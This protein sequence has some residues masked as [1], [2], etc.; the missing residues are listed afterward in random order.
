MPK[1]SSLLQLLER[2]SAPELREIA[3]GRNLATHGTRAKLARRISYDCKRDMGEVV[4]ATGPWSRE[5]WN[6]FV[7]RTFNGA[8]RR[9]FPEIREEIER[10][11]AGAADD[12]L[13]ELLAER[14]TLG[15]LRRD[16]AIARKYADVLATTPRRLLNWLEKYRGNRTLA[17]VAQELVQRF[18]PQAPD[19]TESEEVDDDE[20]QGGEGRDAAEDQQAAQH[21]SQAAPPER[22]TKSIEKPP[23][24]HLLGGR[25]RIVKEL[26]RGG[27][28]TAFEVTNARG[29]VRV[30]KVAHSD[31][32]DTEALIREAEAALEL[33]H[34]NVCR[35]YELEDDKRCGVFAV[36]QHCGESLEARYLKKPAD[37][38]EAI[39]LLAQ[40][41][42]GI[43][44]LHA[45]GIVHGDVSPANILVDAS[46]Q[47]RIT[48]FGIASQMRAITRTA[49][50][51][52]V[53]ELRGRNAVFAAEE[54]N[55]GQAPRRGS[56]QASL[57]KVLCAL[58]LGVEH[59]RREPRMTFQRLGGAQ[60]AVDRALHH[61]PQRRYDNCVGFV[62]ALTGGEP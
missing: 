45:K 35:Y 18:Q 44:Y 12:I 38:T 11:L 57:A 16:P 43:D 41:A 47:A 51:T 2:M 59:Y 13:R 28:G 33:A 55:G 24:G 27:M 25:W 20:P 53:G 3:E 21:L 36:M 42:K 30:A 29:L 9:S 46:G 6:A 52:H 10:G 54:V 60:V 37:P 62:R 23:A 58:L 32:S 61:D 48:D 26:G 40:A 31:G 4:A 15:D 5:Q 49:G 14:V 39:R 34:E 50:M 19:D 7:V 8:A 56:D 22:V 17:S 1:K